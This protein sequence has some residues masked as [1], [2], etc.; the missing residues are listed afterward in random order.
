MEL[1]KY[2]SEDWYR[3]L[4]GYVESKEFEDIAWKIAGERKT[5]T[6]YPEKGSDLLFKVFREVPLNKVKVVIMGQDPYHDGSYDGLAFSNTEE[7]VK[8][9]P[10]LRNILAEVERDC[11]D[12]FDLTSRT[13]FSLYR[14]AEQGVFLIN[15]AHSVVKG[16][17]GSHLHYWKEFTNKMVETLSKKDDVIWLLWGNPAHKFE[18]QITNGTHV[19]I[20][21][22]HPS[23]LNTANPFKGCNCFSRTNKELESKGLTPIKW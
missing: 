11:Y 21:S 4:K 6:V 13:V 20:K 18:T 8:P 19:V 2:F 22:G 23:P 16:V 10:S 1:S 5:R 9:S 15:T 17:P 12:G 14:W 3:E 7:K